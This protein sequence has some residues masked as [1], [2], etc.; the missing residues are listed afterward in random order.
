MPLCPGHVAVPQEKWGPEW[1][2]ARAHPLHCGPVG[3]DGDQASEVS[4]SGLL[5]MAG[6]VLTDQC[7]LVDFTGGK[8]ALC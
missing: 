2:H 7:H 6:L 8:R 3:T 5:P 1:T 4:A